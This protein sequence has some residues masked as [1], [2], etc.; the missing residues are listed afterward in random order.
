MELAEALLIRRDMQKKLERTDVV[1]E[2]T[3]FQ[4]SQSN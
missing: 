2:F 3:V 4:T 1:R